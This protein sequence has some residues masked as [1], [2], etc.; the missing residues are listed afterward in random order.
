MMFRKNKIYRSVSALIALSLIVALNATGLFT[1]G[2]T[3]AYYV[4]VEESLGNLFIA[5][6][7]DFLATSTPW[8]PLAVSLNLQPGTTTEFFI[9]IDPLISNPFQYFASTTVSG[10]LDFCA[11]I[12]ARL[13]QGANELYQGPLAS[14]LS[15]TTTATSTL[16]LA[17]SI[18]SAFYNSVCDFELDF[19]G[20]QTRHHLPPMT[21]FSD[22][23]GITERLASWGMRLN[24]IYYDVEEGEDHEPQQCD[25]KSQGYWKNHEGCN[26]NGTGSSPWYDEV[27]ALSSGFSSVFGATTGGGV[28][29][30]LKTSSCP[31]GSTADGQRCRAKSHTLADELNVVSGRLDLEAIIAGADNGDSAFDHLGLSSLSTVGEALAAVEAVIA[32]G[33]STKDELEDASYV[34]MRIYTFYEYENPQA[35]MCVYDVLEDGGRGEEGKN[36]WVELYNQTDAPQD[37][38]GWFICDNFACDELP[39]GTPSV[40]AGGYAVITNDPGTFGAAGLAPWYLPP[41]VVYIP[42][43]ENIGNGLHN[44]ADML[45]LKRPDGVIVDQMNYGIPDEGWPNW[46]DEVWTPG[47]PDVAEGRLLARVPSGY[48]TDQPSDWHPIIPPTVDLIYPDE[49]GSYTW[50]WGHSY[51]ITWSAVNHNG[52][53]EDLTMTLLV[54]LDDN[55]NSQIDESDTTEVIALTENDGSYEW[56]VPHGFLG[57]IWIKLVATGPENPLNNTR[58]VSGTIYDPEPI[59][60]G[61]E[62]MDAGALDVTPPTITLYGNNPAAIPLGATYQDLGATVEDDVNQNLGYDVEGDVDTS[63]AGVYT[64]TYYAEDQAGNSATAERIV[65]VYDPAEGEPDLSAYLPADAPSETAPADSS[66]ESAGEAAPS[67]APSAPAEETPQADEPQDSPTVLR[68]EDSG[69]A[70]TTPALPDDGAGDGPLPADETA[71]EEADAE[72][73]P[74]ETVEPEAREEDVAPGEEET[75]D[76]LAPQDEPHEDATATSQEVTDEETTEPE[77]IMLEVPEENVEPADVGSGEPLEWSSE[78]PDAPETPVAAPEEAAEEPAAAEPEHV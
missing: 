70:T 49:G 10:D 52:D 30:T 28:C 9:D 22:T 64:L 42:L 3:A 38:S 18:N 56:T 19:N 46:N 26:S 63:V 44:D 73:A 20:W 41:G 68:D 35:P 27:N 65:V 76:V 50:Y 57:Y 55:H 74:E 71:V 8:D 15:A 62:G 36:E 47:V 45:V 60:V 40:P 66:D 33:T 21:G 34:A 59:L 6:N 37:V 16:S 67:A 72:T 14:M 69:E 25:A 24:K 61:P 4:D 2:S 77:S 58:T 23:E 1:I 78:E 39:A 5:G 53:D 48:D 51:D 31:S 43:Y 29:S 32:D 7:V 54:I 13:A 17:A 12:E 11:A 75:G